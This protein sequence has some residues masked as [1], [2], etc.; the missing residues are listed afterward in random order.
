MI[1]RNGGLVAMTVAS[2]LLLLVTVSIGAFFFFH[3]AVSWVGTRFLWSS[4][5]PSP[6]QPSS[7]FISALNGERDS[8]D[9]ASTLSAR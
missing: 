2:V 3:G 8:A 5:L 7:H 6:G 4:A 1:R 9:S